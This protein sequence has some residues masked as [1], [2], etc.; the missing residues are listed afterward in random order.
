[1]RRIV[2]PAVIKVIQKQVV[3]YTCDKCG[4]VCGTRANPKQ[5][6]HGSN[7]AHH[8]CKKTCSPM[9]DHRP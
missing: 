3:E 4:A 9:L 8:Y 2:Q 1:M 6:W 7:G 5:T